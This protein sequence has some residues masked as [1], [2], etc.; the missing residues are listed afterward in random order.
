MEDLNFLKDPFVIWRIGKCEWHCGCDSKFASFEELKWHFFIFHHNILLNPPWNEDPYQALLENRFTACTVHHTLTCKICEE[1]ISHETH[2]LQFHFENKHQCSPLDYYKTHVNKDYTLDEEQ[3]E[4][5]QNAIKVDLV[6]SKMHNLV[7]SLKKQVQC[8]QLDNQDDIKELELNKS[9]VIELEQ[10]IAAMAEKSTKDQIKIVELEKTIVSMKKTRQQGISNQE[11]VTEGGKRKREV[12][13]ALDST[14]HQTFIEESEEGEKDNHIS[15]NR[16]R[17]LKKYKLN[18]KIKEGE[19][20]KTQKH[21]QTQTEYQGGGEKE[22]D[23]KPFKCPICFKGFKYDKGDI[24]N[25]MRT[26]HEGIKVTNYPC[27]SCGTYYHGNKALQIH[28]KT[29]THHKEAAKKQGECKCSLC[30]I[31]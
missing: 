6:F 12:S 28:M 4:L 29:K 27:P 19:E 31:M 30:D 15:E 18:I 5:V 1:E 25:H 8:L 23:D 2:S 10:K 14:T 13:P 3:V 16:N 20:E 11:K 21:Q 26:V 22:N 24:K 7:I 17:S 9:K